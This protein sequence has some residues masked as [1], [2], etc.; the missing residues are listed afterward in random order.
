MWKTLRQKLRH[1][2]T[3]S[4]LRRRA[5]VSVEGSASAMGFQLV[6]GMGSNMEPAA[7]MDRLAGGLLI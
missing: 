3:S 4:R 2:N 7:R 1:I 6:F 5:A